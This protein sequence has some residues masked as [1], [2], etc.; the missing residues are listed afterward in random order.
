[1]RLSIK[2]TF[3]ARIGSVKFATNFTESPCSPLVTFP[4]FCSEGHGVQP[5]QG[6][7]VFC[8]ISVVF[9]FC[10]FVFFR[11]ILSFSTDFKTKLRLFFLNP[12]FSAAT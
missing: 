9:V 7:S 12:T 6:D 10:F 4:S 5:P 1:M 8:Y 11:R 3:N 2:S